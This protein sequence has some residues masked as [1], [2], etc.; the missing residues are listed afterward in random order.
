[1]ALKPAKMTFEQAAAI[2]LAAFTALQGL[3][4][5]GQIKLG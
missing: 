4:D 1:L 5:K 3:R 2:P